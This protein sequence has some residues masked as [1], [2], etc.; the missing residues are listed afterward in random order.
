MCR[1]RLA[2]GDEGVNVGVAGG[3]D[4][5]LKNTVFEIPFL[6]MVTVCDWTMKTRNGQSVGP[7][8]SLL[9]PAAKDDASLFFVAVSGGLATNT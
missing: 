5:R 4:T 3:R 6:F 2:W 9:V 1:G 8:N 7:I